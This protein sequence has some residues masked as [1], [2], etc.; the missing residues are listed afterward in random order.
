MKY[1]TVKCVKK[2]TK[3]D[4]FRSVGALACAKPIRLAWHG[5]GSSSPHQRDVETRKLRMILWYEQ[6]LVFNQVISSPLLIPRKPPAGGLGG[7][8]N[9]CQAS[10]TGFA[11]FDYPLRDGPVTSDSRGIPI[12]SG[13]HDN[14]MENYRSRKHP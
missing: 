2:F 13:V 9:P 8:M 11:N 14:R 3:W 6:P 5:F 10:R 12:S 1:M 7:G 4:L